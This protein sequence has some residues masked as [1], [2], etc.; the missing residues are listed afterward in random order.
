MNGAPAAPPR[1]RFDTGLW[2]LALFTGWMWLQS[3]WAVEPVRHFD[4]A[5]L[6]TKY[7]MLAFLV[8]RLIDSEAALELFGWVHVCGCFWWGWIAFRDY[9]SGRIELDLGAG[10]N[11]SN[12]IG[13]HLVTG[14][15]F[16]GLMLVALPH[17]RRFFTLAMIPFI[18]NA[19][20]LT[21]SRGAVLAMLA[22]GAGSLFFAPRMRRGV[23]Y[24]CAAL[25]VVLFF[26]LAGSELFWQRM[27]TLHV[28]K[29]QEI[30]ASAAS[31]I[32][33]AAANWRMF[34]DYPLGTGYRGNAYLSPR[35]LPERFLTNG[36]RAAH[37]TFFAVLVDEGVVGIVLYGGMMLWAFGTVWRLKRLDAAGLPVMLGT[38]RGAVGA[39]LVAY[40]VAGMFTNFM[41]AEVGIWLVALVSVVD[42]LS[43]PWAIPVRRQA[44][45]PSVP[46]LRVAAV[47]GR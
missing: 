6:F 38:F 24:A 19:V 40:L 23:L 4:G 27:D 39:G 9:T 36:E 31:R 22:A 21:A 18:L 29:G 34:Q 14:L 46:A 5:M 42:R 12:T 1:R 2:L 30:E 10:V 47:P 37:N 43:S 3:L 16:A 35:Y 20:I 8:T 45:V 44:V 13:F 28:E 41:A 15:A 11:D 33:I 25:G 26:R 32:D 17:K 7:T